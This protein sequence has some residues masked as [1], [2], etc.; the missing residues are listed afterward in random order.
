MPKPYELTLRLGEPRSPREL[1]EYTDR[2]VAAYRQRRAEA[3]VLERPIAAARAALLTHLARLGATTGVLD[4]AA[5]TPIAVAVIQ[6]YLLEP[7]ADVPEVVPE[8][9]CNHCLH[10]TARYTTGTG[11]LLCPACAGEAEARR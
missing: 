5:A 9:I 7:V 8:V 1:R 4:D 3:E 10:R 11:A 6:A 2:A